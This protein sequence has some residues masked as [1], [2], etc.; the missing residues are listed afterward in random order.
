[1]SLFLKFHTSLFLDLHTQCA[2]RDTCSN[3]L[4]VLSVFIFNFYL[5][6]ISNELRLPRTYFLSI[7]SIASAFPKISSDI[8]ASWLH[9]RIV[10]DSPL[11][12]LKPQFVHQVEAPVLVSYDLH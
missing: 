3:D 7:D 8:C 1:M 6:V 4:I 9:S 5:S 12:F 10:Y 11:L 2:L